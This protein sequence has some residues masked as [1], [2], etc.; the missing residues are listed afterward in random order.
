[1]ST[2]ANGVHLYDIGAV[3]KDIT[4]GSNQGLMAV[5]TV[6]DVIR[7]SGVGASDLYQLTVLIRGSNSSPVRT[8]GKL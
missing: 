3:A 4:Q 5:Y 1:M 2:G 6:G 8:V 7:D